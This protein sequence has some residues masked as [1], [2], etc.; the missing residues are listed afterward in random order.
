MDNPISDIAGT[1][2][3]SGIARQSVVDGPGLRLVVF[4]QGCPH[5]CP[6]CHNP[7]TH[8]FGGGYDCKISRILEIYDANPLLKG[9][10][11]SGGE[12][13]CRAGELLPLCR[14]VLERGGNIVCYSGYTFEEL[15]A[16]ADEDSGARELLYLIDLLIDGRFLLERRDLTLRFRGSLNQRV[17][18]LPVSL[19][20]NAPV[21]AKGYQ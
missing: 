21:W 2:R 6:G 11:I 7:E 16:M 17:L 8:D 10:T 15:L 9:L 18:D 4:T 20:K 5:L 3:I 1:I 13:F 19:G 12:P 14:A